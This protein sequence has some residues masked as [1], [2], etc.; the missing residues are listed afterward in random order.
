MRSLSGPPS[1]H[2]HGRPRDLPVL[3]MKRSHTCSG[4]LTPRDPSATRE[5]ATND[6]AFRVDERVGIPD[7]KHFEAQPP[8]PT[9]TPANASLRP[10]GSPTHDSGP[11]RLR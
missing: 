11:S 9:C 3:S 8:R 2:S 10:H 5:N 6:V 1:H 4:S 7:K